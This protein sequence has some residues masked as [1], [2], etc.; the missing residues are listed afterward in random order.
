MSFKN[1]S[2]LVHR[3]GCYHERLNQ[4]GIRQLFDL[5]VRWRKELDVNNTISEECRK[6]R[7]IGR[8]W[9]A[10][11]RAAAF[12]RAWVDTTEALCEALGFDRGTEQSRDIFDLTSV[13]AFDSYRVPTATDLMTDDEL[14]AAFAM[15]AEV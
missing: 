9:Q 15:F 7:E 4:P 11:G 3:Y 14:D 6:R 12:Q 10:G 5:A 8:K 2:H 1:P 13:C